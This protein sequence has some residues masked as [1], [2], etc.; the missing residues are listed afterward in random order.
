MSG[1]RRSGFSLIEVLVALTLLAVGLALVFA[2]VRG[3]TRATARAEAD[4]QRGERLRA[5]QALLRGRLGQAMALPIE[6]DPD[7]GQASFFHGEPQRIQFIA[8]MPGY[9]SYGGPYLQT[10]AL[11]PGDHGRL[12]LQFVFQLMTPDGPLP[13]VREPQVLLDAVESGGFEFRTLDA[14]S[15]PAP[16]QTEW[17]RPAQLP[18]LLRLRLRLAEGEG[19]WPELAV[20][21][22]A[23][24]PFASPPEN[25]GAGQ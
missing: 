25:A 16:W 14:N 15:R 18:P 4:A 22:Q 3:A 7:T 23:G 5:V 17:K 9:L 19:I 21:L 1:F 11:V 20:R 13:P 2:T 10:L 12:R 24:V 8:P 6:I